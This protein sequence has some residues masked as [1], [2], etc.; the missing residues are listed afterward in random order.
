M[1]Q[2]KPSFLLSLV[3]LVVFTLVGCG[4]PPP[5]GS[6]G[7]PPPPGSSGGAAPGLV[8]LDT[9]GDSNI[10]GEVWADNWFALYKSDGLLIEDSVSINTER[11]FNAETF[12]FNTDY[13]LMLN[14]IVKDF[15]ENDTGL[16]YIGARNQQMGDGGFIAQFTDTTTGQVIAATSAN[17]KCMVI[18]EAPLDKS[19][20]GESNP[21]A[22]QGA[23][24]FIAL[25][26]PSGWQGIDF[27]DSGW[28]NATVY[29]ESQVS[30]KDGYDQI[31]WDSSAQLIW[32]SDLETDNTLLC[33]LKVEQP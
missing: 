7:A 10:K 22:G 24:G 11:S 3:S 19:C 2:I 4:A 8:K 9:S 21:V 25:D 18:H 5:P 29:S 30:P 13:P 6:S 27:D 14:F 31:S 12:T 15:K 1:Q 26:E 28:T 32:G 16:E 20:E 17:W 23:C 33:R